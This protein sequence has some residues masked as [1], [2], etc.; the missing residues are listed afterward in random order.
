MQ[1]GGYEILALGVCIGS[2]ADANGRPS[3]S[4][5]GDPEGPPFHLLDRAVA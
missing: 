3:Q 1:N 5:K 4:K 2:K